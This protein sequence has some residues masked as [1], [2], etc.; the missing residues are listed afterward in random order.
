MKNEERDDLPE[1]SA[2]PAD[3]FR[4]REN[5]IEADGE[6]MPPVNR[7]KKGGKVGNALLLAAV[8]LAGLL[9]IYMVNTGAAKKQGAKAE[10]VKGISSNNLPP[11]VM[12]APQLPPPPPQ[13]VASVTPH[14]AQAGNGGAGQAGKGPGGKTVLDW[15]D[16]KLI[17]TVVVAPQG[18][19]QQAQ[20]ARGAAHVPGGTMPDYSQFQQQERQRNDLENRLEPTPMVGV[21]ASLLADR[22]FLITKGTSLDCALE[23]AIDTTLPGI[24][25]CRLTRDVYSDNG[26]VL[27]LERGTQLVGEQQGNVKRG[28]ARVFA[29]WSRAKTPNGV[30]INLN[31]PGA[32]AL[33]RSGLDGWVDSH[34]AERFG[35]AILMSVIQSSLEIMV[36]RQKKTEG[37]AIL[38]DTSNRGE[39]VVSKI[40]DSSI[41]IP[42]TIIK[43]QG[44]HINVMV[45]RDL[46]FS[47]VYGLEV[48]Q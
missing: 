33:G 22:N 10:D 9:L 42:P 11:L 41:N 23:T 2:S 34:F 8:G 15:T 26:Q 27:L 46:D 18:Q 31:S 39:D 30:I 44:D 36:E 16:R 12:P 5:S 32:D 38:E 40:L 35:A 24:L 28:Q 6:G 4:G 20:Q 37:G 19:G 21:S 14:S 25:T 3:D 7:K 17:G 47:T 13:T 43:N 1:L 48:R 45:A 29:L